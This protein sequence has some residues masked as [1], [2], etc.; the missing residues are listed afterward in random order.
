WWETPEDVVDKIEKLVE[1]IHARG[2]THGDL[3][4][5]NVLVDENGEIAI[6][7]WATASS[8]STRRGMAKNWTFDE[9]RGLDERALAKIKIVHVSNKITPHQHEL[10]LHGGSRIYRFVKQF[11]GLGERIRGVDE[12]TVAQRQRKQ[13]KILRRLEKFSPER[14]E[15]EKAT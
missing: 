4:G 2:I 10:L 14:D 3:H 15:Q 6:I 5:Y 8:F 9:W 1:Q 13:D 7:D 11:K 12:S